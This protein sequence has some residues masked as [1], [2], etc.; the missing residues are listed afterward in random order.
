MV[1][2]PADGIPDRLTEC[3][4]A[5]YPVTEVQVLLVDYRLAALLP[6]GSGEPATRPGD[7][8]LRCFDHQEPTPGPKSV[9]LPVTT[10]GDRLGVLRLSPEPEDPADVAELA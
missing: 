1:A 6:L 9:H 3:L 10:R 5:R 2:A 8:A 4:I 7:P